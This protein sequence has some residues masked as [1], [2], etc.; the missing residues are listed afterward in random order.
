MLS[1]LLLFPLLLPFHLLD[2]EGRLLQEHYHFNLVEW[3]QPP[4]HL[5]LIR[6]LYPLLRFL[7]MHLLYPWVAPMGFSAPPTTNQQ[8]QQQ[9]GS[10]ASGP[11]KFSVPTTRRRK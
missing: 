1:L 6:R 11:R 3:L 10:S 7:L 5:E 9:Q 8:Q 2:S 4:F